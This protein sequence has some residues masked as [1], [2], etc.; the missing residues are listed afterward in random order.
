MTNLIDD[1]IQNM[2]HFK[3]LRE[4]VERNPKRFPSIVKLIKKSAMQGYFLSSLK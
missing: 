2:K 3:R 4:R 1:L